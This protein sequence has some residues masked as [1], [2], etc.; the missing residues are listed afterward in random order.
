MAWDGLDETD[1]NDYRICFDRQC[2]LLVGATSEDSVRRRLL[3]IEWT[4][5]RAIR[6]S[7]VGA[8]IVWILLIL[9]GLGFLL[10]R[11]NTAAWWLLFGFTLFVSFLSYWISRFAI[12]YNISRHLR[13]RKFGD[14]NG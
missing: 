13:M 1:G 14:L 7:L 11:G 5:W 3:E 8:S 12:W 4:L 2:K 6:T 9:F 10:P